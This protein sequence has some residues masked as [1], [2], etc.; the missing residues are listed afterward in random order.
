VSVEGNVIRHVATYY[1]DLQI[2]T[3][4]HDFSCSVP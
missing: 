4:I 1:L 2:V 3:L